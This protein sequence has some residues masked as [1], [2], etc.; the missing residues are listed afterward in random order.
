MQRSSN[1]DCSPLEV[2]IILRGSTLPLSIVW[3]RCNS[4]GKDWTA[5]LHEEGMRKGR[6]SG[7]RC[8]SFCM[9]KRGTPWWLLGLP[10]GEHHLLWWPE[11]S[12]AEKQVSMRIP[13][14]AR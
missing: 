5:P 1:G 3:R 12:I 4:G 14:N 10:A 6:I 7:C 8:R 13:K 2:S 11:A 9:G